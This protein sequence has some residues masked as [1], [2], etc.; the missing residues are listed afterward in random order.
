MKW[1]SPSQNAKEWLWWPSYHIQIQKCH[2]GSSAENTHGSNGLQAEFFQHNASLWSILSTDV[3]NEITPKKRQLP[4]SLRASIILLLCKKRATEKVANY[5]IVALVNL[6]AKNITF[7][8][9]AFLKPVLK[10][11]IPLLQ[12][13]F[14]PSRETAE[15][16]IIPQ[17]TAHRAKSKCKRPILLCLDFAKAYDRVHWSYR[18][19]I[20]HRQRIEAKRVKFIEALCSKQEAALWISENV[21]KRFKV[22][23]G[24]LQE[25]NTS[26][27]L[28]V[29]QMVPLSS[30]LNILRKTYG[31]QVSNDSIPQTG[32]FYANAS[33]L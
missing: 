5:G 29:L 2:K 18:T 31:I 9:S 14:I 28:F 13:S 21:C 10:Y 23:R 17:Y 19:L 7:V 12:A 20:L 26:P 15:S 6:A 25:N 30:V 1:S 32:S 4:R 24:V 11:L 8:F 27:F 22:S 3:P 16:S 33:T